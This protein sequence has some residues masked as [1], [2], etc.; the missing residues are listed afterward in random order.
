MVNTCTIVVFLFLYNSSRDRVICSDLS[1]DDSGGHNGVLPLPEEEIQFCLLQTPTPSPK[2]VCR[3]ETVLQRV[4]GSGS[5]E[6]APQLMTTVLLLC[7][8]RTSGAGWRALGCYQHLG[9]QTNKRLDL[10]AV[11][12]KSSL[13]GKLNS[14][15]GPFSLRGYGNTTQSCSWSLLHSIGITCTK[16]K[17]QGQRDG[18]E[19]GSRHAVQEPDADHFVKI[20]FY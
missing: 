3:R 6:P 2:A 12:L 15:C 18:A 1:T 17:C 14:P 20:G 13:P 5:Q 11:Q 19:I 7:P 9:Q 8:L 4:P 16:L 10:F